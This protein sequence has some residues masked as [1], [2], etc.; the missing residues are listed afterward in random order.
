MNTYACFLSLAL[1]AAFTA[2]GAT[3]AGTITDEQS[4]PVSGA[5]ETLIST[6][7]GL[8]WN[9]V[10]L[11]SGA[12]RFDNLPAGDYIL[13]V[14]APGFA[15]YLAQ[16][17]HLD[18]SSAATHD[19]SL[20][21]AGLR[22]EIVVTASSTPQTPAEVSKSITVIDPAE[23]EGRDVPDLG[24]ALDLAPGVRVEQLGGPGALSEI[25][26]RGLRPEDTAVLVDGLRLRDASATQA[27]AS[28]L[29]E[30]FLLTDSSQ[31]E[32]LRGVGSSLYGT[33]AIGGVVNVITDHGGGR[34][35]GGVL[36]EGG[37]LG[38]GRAHAQLGGGL[39][40]GLLQYSFGA[41]ELYV[42]NGVGGTLPYR[43]TTVQGSIGFHLSPTTH[44]IARLYG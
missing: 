17:I 38:L 19:V 10:S 37:S 39:H 6:T 16:P 11:A 24:A 21:V 9:S 25:H 20:R 3:L 27:D 23:V 34:M 14:D 41:S 35:H 28:G 5:T 18:A 36:V 7:N 32:V 44:L 13:Q 43:D 22:E 15:T 42:A 33:N 2:Q 31:I 29:I 4:R 1:A 12:Y 26:I 30:D 8:R 40:E